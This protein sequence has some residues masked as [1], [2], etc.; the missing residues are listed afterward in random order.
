LT[1]RLSFTLYNTFVFFK[2]V[3]DAVDVIAVSIWH[4][5]NDLVIAGSRVAKKHIRNASY[6]ITNA[7]LAHLPLPRISTI[8]CTSL[9]SLLP[10]RRQF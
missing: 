4:R 6:H 8:C 1:R 10:K 2:R 9:C 3:L 7:E 5:G